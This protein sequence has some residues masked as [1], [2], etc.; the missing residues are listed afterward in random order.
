M[1]QLFSSFFSDL[2]LNQFC[3]LYTMVVAS[4]VGRQVLVV[5]LRVKYLV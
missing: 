3:R 1:I 2:Q 4:N 5:D